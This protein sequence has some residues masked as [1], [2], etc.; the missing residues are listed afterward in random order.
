M[1]ERY[2]YGSRVRDV[3]SLA[4]KTEEGVFPGGRVDRNPPANTGKMNSISGLGDS[5]RHWAMKPEATTTEATHRDWTVAPACHERKIRAATEKIVFK[6]DGR[7]RPQAK[8]AGGLW[9]PEEPQEQVHRRASLQKGMP[10]C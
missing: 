10:S 4:L 8:T 2:E 5:T 7:K 1:E 6:K 3:R 9:K